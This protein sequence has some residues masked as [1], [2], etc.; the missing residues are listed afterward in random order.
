ML[1]LEQFFGLVKQF[2]STYAN[3]NWSRHSISIYPH[4]LSR[5]IRG[6]MQIL[7]PSPPYDN[8][9]RSTTHST[10]QLIIQ[11]FRQACDEENE[12][13]L[14]LVN[15]FPD[16]TIQSVL[17]LTLSGQNITEL[18]QWI[19]YMKSR[20]AHFLTDC[21][22]NC[23][24]FIQTDHRVESRGNALERFYSLGFQ[25]NEKFISRHQ[26]FYRALKKF[27]DQFIVCPW[28]TKTMKLSYKLVSIK[29]W[30]DERSSN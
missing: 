21:E 17:Q 5:D 19:G 28:R 13:I 23:Q 27:L 29:Q 25:F 14:D 22:E 18:N 24:L 1:S 2:F 26:E 30:Q 4:H 10:Q 3:F 11:A 20:L 8:S 15:E 7:C 6:T 9:S 16:S 12:M